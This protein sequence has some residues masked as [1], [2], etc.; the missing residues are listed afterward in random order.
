MDG[1][2][3]TTWT[4]SG[5]TESFENISL[6]GSSGR[7]VEVLGVLGAFEWLSIVEVSGLLLQRGGAVAAALERR[8]EP[9]FSTTELKAVVAEPGAAVIRSIPE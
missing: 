7:V 8:N 1:A 9:S 4:S 3:I 5:A 6:S 2:L